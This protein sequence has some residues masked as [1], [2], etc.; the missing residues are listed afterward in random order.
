MS[1]TTGEFKTFERRLDNCISMRDKFNEGEWG[2]NFW[3]T[4][5]STILRNMNNRLHSSAGSEQRS[6]KP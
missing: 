2:Y 1:M 5:F 3:S 6:S 4:R